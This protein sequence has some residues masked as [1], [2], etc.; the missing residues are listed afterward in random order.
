MRSVVGRL[1]RVGA[2]AVVLGAVTVAG[3]LVAASPAVAGGGPTITVTNCSGSASTPGSLPAAVV[4][5]DATSGTTIGFAMSP[6]CSRI[7][8]DSSLSITSDMSIEGPG[9]SSLTV[10]G[11]GTVRAIDVS[12]TAALTIS[13]LT[14]SDS[15][16]EGVLNEGTGTLTISDATVAGTIGNPGDGVL[17]PYNGYEG[18][19]I[20]VTGSTISGNAGDGVAHI[21]QYS[22]SPVSITGSTISANGASGVE[23]R[24]SSSV[25]V[26]NSTIAGNGTG[27]SAYI[28][29][30]LYVDNSTI[31]GNTHSGIASSFGDVFAET[32]ISGSLVSGNSPDC[33]WNDWNNLYGANLYSVEDDSTCSAGSSVNTGSQISGA[34]AIWTP[35]ASGALAPN[36]STGPETEAITTS[37]AAHA[38]VPNAYCPTTDERGDPRPASG[39]CDAGAYQTQGSS[40]P[41]PSTLIIITTSGTYGTP[42]VLQTLGA[43]G[44]LPNYFV[45]DPG[46]A[47][48][49]FSNVM[50][51]N[52]SSPGTC[53]VTAFFDGSSSAP[54]TITFG[55][56]DQAPLAI[57]S[58]SG[59]SGSP[60]VLAT[61]GG[62]DSGPVSYAVDSSGTAGCTVAG[63][64]LS[65]TSVGTCAVTATMAGN[66]DYNP[67][68]SAPTTITISPA[69]TR[70]VLRLSRSAVTFG[71]EQAERLSVTVTS[72][73]G[74]PVGQVTITGTSCRITLVDGQG[75]CTL[76]KRELAVSKHPYLL[77][78]SYL[79]G[80][81]FAPSSS[82]GEHL[83]VRA[84]RRH[85]AAASAA[86]GPEARRLFH[87][88][89]SSGFRW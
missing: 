51:L 72:A 83:R 9:S 11:G 48:C 31:S 40:S 18:G 19:S 35:G 77:T 5:A 3:S 36:G 15:D 7:T 12:G 88:E 29:F 66:T 52:A 49:S 86:G 4:T 68:S 70:A 46:T 59:T 32:T 33:S 69:P 62:S 17:D 54:T 23:I 82:G 71:Q 43:V 28:D 14:I 24:H 56:A 27:I 8:L 79:G 61:S 64:S 85:A 13:G 63:S 44:G 55:P 50:T 38:I 67:V 74:V 39:N 84:A 10:S 30:N 76:A 65:A 22:D 87:W 2:A 25:T 20:V 81:D 26:K 41:A 73:A 1:T 37:S 78:A 60:L 53:V 58:T 75:S 16:N 6:A 42:L 21:G 45:N 89:L 34:A 80:T 47:G 57:T